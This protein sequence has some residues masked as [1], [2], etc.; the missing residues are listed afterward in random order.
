MSQ[1][2]ETRITYPQENTLRFY[3][4]L[5]KAVQ[6][7]KSNLNDHLHTVPWYNFFESILKHPFN[8]F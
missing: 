2:D 5:F 8:H 4:N 3:I 1:N 7:P 6:M